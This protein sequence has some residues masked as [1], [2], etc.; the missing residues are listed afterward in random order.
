[1]RSDALIDVIDVTTYRIP[2]DA[3][4]ADGTL[5]WCATDLLLVEVKGGGCSGLGYSYTAAAAAAIL[6]RDLLT[7]P[8]LK[9]DAF[10]IPGLW[11]SM[12]RALRNA[13]RPGL[14]LMAIS[15][16][17]QAL[18]DLKAKLLGVSLTTLWG[19]CRES[20]PLYAS[21]G[22]TNYSSARLQQQLRGWAE[23]QFPAV[24]MKL[25]G[26]LKNDVRHIHEAR[27]AIGD[28]VG[29]MVDANGA[30]Q[31]RQAQAL[32]D[33]LHGCD[34]CWFE[35]P[36]SSDDLAGLRWLR[37]Q[38]PPKLAIAAGE[39][40]WDVDY[41][42]HMLTIGA[43]DVLQADATRC[44]YTGFLQVA[45]LGDAFHTPI[46]AHCAPAIHA[47]LCTAIPNLQH[48]EYFHDHVRIES[49]IFDGLPEL[50]DGALWPDINCLGHGLSL[51]REALDKY[52]L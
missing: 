44:G 35:E 3:C 10:D 33:D 11:L 7:P 46:S 12:N 5:E 13:G 8:L 14:G 22:F 24:K 29:L 36:V 20:V 38:A 31:P 49:M 28:R 15:A 39:Y 52:R 16:V 18:W 34:V 1:M 48:L 4:E 42:R 32:F 21:G 37:D 26:E 30:Y 40:G 23:Q 43:V 27:A 47:P 45:P 25:S 9:Q 19:R 6:I 41:Y 51:R 50:H 17:D 2:T